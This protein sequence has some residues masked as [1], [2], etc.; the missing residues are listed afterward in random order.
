M[1]VS[2][3]STGVLPPEVLIQEALKILIERC[4]RITEAITES[5]SVES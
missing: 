2:V 3:E 5:V 4:E 1:I